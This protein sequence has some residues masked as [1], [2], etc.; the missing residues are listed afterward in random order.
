MSSTM[1]EEETTAIVS[2]AAVRLQSKSCL[3][4][5]ACCP[6]KDLVVLV[7]KATGADERL[8]LWKLQGAK[9]WEVDLVRG[10]VGADA[11]AE[12]E[13]VTGLTWSPDGESNVSSYR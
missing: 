10:A 6:D 9:K 13:L 8:S 7:S 11:N 5:T 12:P 3:F 1:E 2:L 4:P